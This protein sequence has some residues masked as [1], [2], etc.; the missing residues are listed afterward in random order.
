MLEDSIAHVA[1]DAQLRALAEAR[2]EAERIAA[3]TEGALAADADLVD[4]AE[5]AAIERALAALR[6]A[7]AGDDRAALTSAIAVLNAATE[8]FAGRRMDRGVARALAGR[9]VDALG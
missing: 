3:A 1:D 7:A 4:A 9:R 8:E 2:V 6:Q 5:R